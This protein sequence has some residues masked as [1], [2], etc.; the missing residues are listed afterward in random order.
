MSGAQGKGTVVLLEEPGEWTMGQGVS[1]HREKERKK[2]FFLLTSPH[3]LTLKV[4]GSHREGSPGETK[5]LPRR[6]CK[7]MVSIVMDLGDAW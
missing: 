1:M 2:G 7:L 4:P 3:H 5:I 6:G